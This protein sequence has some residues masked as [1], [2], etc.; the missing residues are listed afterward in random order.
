MIRQNATD[1]KAKQFGFYDNDHAVE[2]IRWMRSDLKW[3]IR[4]IADYLGCSYEYADCQLLPEQRKRSFIPIKWTPCAADSR[5]RIIDAH[6]GRPSPMKGKR[7]TL[8]ARKKMSEAG[9]G[10]PSPLKGSSIPKTKFL[11]AN[12]T[13]YGFYDNIQAIEIIR[14]IKSEFGWTIK[15]IMDYLGCPK[16][17]IYSRLLRHH[18]RSGCAAWNRG[19][20]MPHEIKKKISESTTGE[21]SCHWRGGV[22]MNNIATYDTYAHRLYPIEEVRRDPNNPVLLQ[23]RC[24]YCGRWFNPSYTDVGSRIAVIEGRQTGEMRLYCGNGCKKDCPVYRQRKYPK[25]HKKPATSRE[26]QP[27]LRKIVFERDKYE[28]QICGTTSERIHC[29]HIEAV[30]LNPIESADIDNCITLCIHCHR[31]VH[32]TKGCTP[33]DLRCADREAA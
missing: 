18:T 30:I 12:A 23:V 14:W 32:R 25:G 19:V 1:S 20:P 17:Y 9:K 2:I 11:D 26:V 10:K 8:E 7:H 5:Q 3:K 22:T 4:D 31:M 27:D 13:K 21:K 28:C 33:S 6:K 29:H 15:Q 16:D 24:A